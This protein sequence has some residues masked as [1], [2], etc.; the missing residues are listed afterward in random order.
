MNGDTQSLV[1]GYLIFAALFL[2]VIK[3]FRGGCCGSHSDK[4]EEQVCKVKACSD[5][6]VKK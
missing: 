6:N 1:F 5:N 4:Q 2:F 3:R